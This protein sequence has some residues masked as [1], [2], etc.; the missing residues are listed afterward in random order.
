MNNHM[1]SKL[2]VCFNCM[3]LKIKLK[4][5]FNS[6]EMLKWNVQPIGYIK[7]FCIF[8]YFPNYMLFLMIVE[9]VEKI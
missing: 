8:I 5:C 9:N 4:L 1:H 7:I 6:L 2:I 3:Y